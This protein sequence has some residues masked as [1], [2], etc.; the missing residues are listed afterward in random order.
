MRTYTVFLAVLLPLAASFTHA[1]HAAAP[2]RMENLIA[3]YDADNS[4]VER[5]Y[6][7]PWSAERFDRL[8][9]LYSTWLAK[10]ATVDFNALDH[11]GKVDYVLLRNHLERSLADLARQ[12]QRLAEMKDL[13][14]F[15]GVIDELEIARLRGARVDMQATAAKIGQLAEQ[16]KKLQ[17][18][19]QQGRA[20]GA[21]PPGPA[22]WL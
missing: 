13:L 5:F 2:V 8:D 4:S 10:L 14:A 9:K 16:V 17:G 21:G 6:D 7:L 11:S 15:R 3:E 1:A 22:R 20:A 12:R 19:V 18:R